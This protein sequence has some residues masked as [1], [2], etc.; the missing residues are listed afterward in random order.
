MEL[1]PGDG[2]ELVESAGS[3]EVDEDDGLVEAVGFRFPLV[4]SA[5]V[6]WLGVVLVVLGYVESGVLTVG[7]VAVELLTEGVV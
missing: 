4:V 6:L 2:V 3:F 7:D 5:V 1:V